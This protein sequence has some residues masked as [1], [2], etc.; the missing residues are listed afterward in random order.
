MRK[1]PLLLEIAVF[2][3]LVRGPS[4][5]KYTPS[6]FKRTQFPGALPLTRTA[7][8]CVYAESANNFSLLPGSD[9]DNASQNGQDNRRCHNDANCFRLRNRYVWDER[10]NGRTRIV[11]TALFTFVVVGAVV[12]SLL[13]L[14]LL[15][16]LLLMLSLLFLCCCS[17]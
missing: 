12:A 8:A 6:P 7:V 5:R 16:L 1:S 15:S 4:F 17:C 9:R 14:L 3:I 13:L 10:N 11:G 2:A